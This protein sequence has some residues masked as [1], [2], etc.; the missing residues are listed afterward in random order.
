MRF[1]ELLFL[2]LNRH[3]FRTTALRCSFVNVG[4]TVDS[5][6]LRTDRLRRIW[7]IRK[8]LA[9]TR[10]MLVGAFLHI[11]KSRSSGNLW[12]P[13]TFLPNAVES[14]NPKDNSI[15]HRSLLR[16]GR[17]GTVLYSRRLSITAE[18]PMDLTMFPFDQQVCK[19]EIESCKNKCH[20][21]FEC[22]SASFRRLSRHRSRL[23]L[24]HQ[25]HRRAARH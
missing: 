7:A 17:A 23:R 18:C 20:Q 14:S 11:V 5:C 13:D 4:T 19:L 10:A 9:C 24:A 22:F 6:G 16:L 25:R 1:Y 2:Q 12:H 8:R 3:S 21:L 15:T